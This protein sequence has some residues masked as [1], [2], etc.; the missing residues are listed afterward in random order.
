MKIS[1]IGAGYVGG[2]L[3]D[4][5]VFN[6]N[7]F[8]VVLLDVNKNLALAKAKDISHALH[9]YKLESGIIG[10]DDYSNL[11]SSDIVVITAGKAR[12]PGMT[13]DD[14]A[15]FNLKVM[16]SVTE[17]IVKY[18]PEAIIIAVTNPVDI[19]LYFIKHY[20]NFNRFKIIGMAGILDS[21]RLS[22]I[23]QEHIPEYSAS[24]IESMIVG[25]HSTDMICL[26]ELT[27]ING[28][29]ILELFSSDELENIYSEVLNAGS[30]M[31]SLYSGNSAYYGPSAAVCKMID[32]I[33]N[34]CKDDCIVTCS[35][36]LEGEYGVKD[37][38]LGVPVV[39]GASG[40]EKIIEIDCHVLPMVRMIET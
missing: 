32:L 9:V 34:P 14:L 27:T 17:N 35:V 22:S 28:R 19:L 40:I 18:C 15:K 36:L 12:Q 25:P 16:K 20:G 33:V 26:P 10:T 38:C 30:E 4:R 23:L 37:V 24:V 7:N 11:K 39:L 6:K 13:R 8:Q 2:Q 1:V 5:L 31:V 29:K 21:A 3:A